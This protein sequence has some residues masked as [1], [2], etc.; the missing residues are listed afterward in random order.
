MNMMGI[1]EFSSGVSSTATSAGADVGNN[2]SNKSHNNFFDPHP[3]F[4]T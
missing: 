4:K 3:R 1:L 2:M